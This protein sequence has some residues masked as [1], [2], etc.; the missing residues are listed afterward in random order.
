MP[1]VQFRVR[2]DRRRG[3]REERRGRGR[4][5]VEGREEKGERREEGGE[6]REE[7]GERGEMRA[8]ERKEPTS[9]D[10]IG[11]RVRKEVGMTPGDGQALEGREASHSSE[12]H[13]KDERHGHRGEEG[14]TWGAGGA[15]AEGRGGGEASCV[16]GPDRL[17]FRHANAV[18]G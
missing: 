10:Q 15:R 8:G 11:N 5:R 12:T 13:P 6:G 4:E 7:R 14:A 9:D 3:R 18:N 1:A 2:G 17:G 16:Q